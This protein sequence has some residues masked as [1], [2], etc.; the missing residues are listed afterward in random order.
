MTM[1]NNPHIR[2][3]IILLILTAA[4]ALSFFI[5]MR[6]FDILY[7]SGNMIGGPDPWFYLRQVELSLANGLGNVSY[8]PYLLFPGGGGTRVGSLFVR[9]CAVVALLFGCVTQTDLI[10][11]LSFVPA[12]MGVCMVPV[13]YFLGKKCGG[14]AAGVLAALFIAVIGGQF[15][16]RTLYG[17]VD[18][19]AL[20]TL[21]SSLFCLSYIAGL[22]ALKGMGEKHTG[23]KNTGGGRTAGCWKTVVR[24]PVIYG[25]IAGCTFF[26]GFQNLYVM[27]LFALIALIY[28]IIQFVIN[29]KTR[30]PSEPLL[31]F[32]TAVFLPAAAG[33]FV[34]GIT[35]VSEYSAVYLFLQLFV[36][37]V[38]LI[39]YALSKLISRFEKP[40]Y[41]LPVSFAG[42][43]ALAALI[44]RFA[45][46]PVFT[47]VLSNFTF[48][49]GFSPT[50]NTVGEMST[51]SLS[52]AFSSYNLFLILAAGGCVWMAV[53]LWNKHSPAALFVLVWTAVFLPATCVHVRTEYYFAV[54]IA[55]LAAVCVA[56][57]VRFTKDALPKRKSI[58]KV[59]GTGAV[60]EADPGTVAA[61]GPVSAPETVSD[62]VLG[63][64]IRILKTVLLILTVVLALG[65]FGISAA[66]SVDMA[67]SSVAAGTVNPYW[68][69]TCEWIRDNTPDPGIPFIDN[70]SRD[71]IYE[72]AHPY[73][74]FSWWDYGYY[75]MEIGKRLPVTNPGQAR[76]AA[77][78]R[79]LLS[80][81][82]TDIREQLEALKVKYVI[83]DSR[84]CSSSFPAITVWADPE[85]QTKPYL[86]MV[87]RTEGNNAEGDNADGSP[88]IL[89]TPAPAYYETLLIRLHR[90]D[91]SL[92][93]P[94]K[95]DGVTSGDI[96]ALTC[97]RLV[98]ESPSAQVK[99]FELVDGARIA[100]EGTIE[101]EVTTD[102]GQR[103][104]Y[105]QTSTDGEFVVPY[106][107]GKNGGVTASEY[108]I[109]ETGERVSV[110]EGAVREMVY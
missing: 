101:C 47:S 59:I 90:F 65:G 95:T 62:A 2:T 108:R 3:L 9:I 78:A 4:A 55:L 21:I 8:D 73:G 25:L 83:T 33:Y 60:P 29:Q 24:K 19:H 64:R 63:K 44:L 48:F 23:E 110:P 106:V 46:E 58:R 92:V 94:D 89:S 70:Y 88:D 12:V 26:L 54:C 14:R 11:V 30:S 61:A 1:K 16:A 86:T 15:L 107:T 45:A 102:Q 91:G 69:E 41:V 99:V 85:A 56:E 52:Q 37:I 93:P 97:F 31:I 42:L 20:E 96:P 81:D 100:G 87:N 34:C 39:L 77:A 22:C 53:K 7:D 72:S 50:M 6:S 10:N 66:V 74:V 28:T 36:V 109:I 84:M 98:H 67:V 80:P 68:Y 18:H 49:F 13:M 35:G 75:I 27:A 5:R 43:T 32:N 105:R 71:K 38:T 57:T 17:Y 76:A 40:W 103:F 82:E 79:I 51:W 104:T